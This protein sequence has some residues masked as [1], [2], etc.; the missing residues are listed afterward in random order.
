[1]NV[2]L[3]KI[4]LRRI[5]SELAKGT[6]STPLKTL[7]DKGFVKPLSTYAKGMNEG[8]K[9][10]AKKIGVSISKGSGR[11]ESS[12]ALGGG[13]AT[14]A[15]KDGRI[16]VVHSGKKS[17]IH[18]VLGT[19]SRLSVHNPALVRHEIFEA[20]DL[21]RKRSAGHLNTPSQTDAMK[22]FRGMIDGPHVSK[23]VQNAAL[24]HAASHMRVA[25]PVTTSL[26][27]NQAGA[28]VGS[29]MS[30]RVLTRESEMVRK[31]PYLDR[32]KSL[33]TVTGESDVIKGITGKR[34]GVDVMRPKDHEAA[35]RAVPDSVLE[36]GTYKSP[37]F[38]SKQK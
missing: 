10:M 31:N 3:E 9:A 15:Y 23:E 14:V 1:M 36:V 7:A 8:N 26:F 34:F 30:P 11:T 27:Q 25:K 12:A 32:L 6:V 37:V 5:V 35:F 24:R 18:K 13:F 38:K 28:T 29:H 2:Y 20:Q 17:E 4:A 21:L 19:D 22:V 33:R 16:G